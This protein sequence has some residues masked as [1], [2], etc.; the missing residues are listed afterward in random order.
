MSPHL[1][2]PAGSQQRK[3]L[4]DADHPSLGA[5]RRGAE[6]R[7]FVVGVGGGLLRHGLQQS[8]R[9]GGGDLL[10]LACW[11]RARARV[12]L[13]LRVAAQGHGV[14]PAQGNTRALAHLTLRGSMPPRALRPPRGEEGRRGLHG[15]LGA[16]TLAWRHAPMRPRGMSSNDASAFA[17]V[18]ET[19]RRASRPAQSAVHGCDLAPPTHCRGHGRAARRPSDALARRVRRRLSGGERRPAVCLRR[20]V[21]LA[22]HA[23]GVHAAANRRPWHRKGATRALGSRSATQ[24]VVR[25]CAGTC[26]SAIPRRGSGA[27]AAATLGA[28]RRSRLTPRAASQDCGTA[29]VDVMAGFM[30]D[31]FGAPTTLVFIAV[32]PPTS[33]GRGFPSAHAAACALRP[34][35][36]QRASL[37]PLG[38]Q[39]AQARSRV[40]P[41]LR[42]QVLNASGFLAIL[43]AYKGVVQTNYAGMV[44]LP[45]RCG[46]R[47]RRQRSPAWLT[48]VPRAAGDIHSHRLWGQ[49]RDAA[50]RPRHD[51]GQLPGDP[52]HGHRPDEVGVLPL[53]L[54]VYGG[55]QQQAAPAATRL[56][57]PARS[58]DARPRCVSRL[59]VVP[60]AGRE[61]GAIPHPVGAAACSRC[62]C[63]HP[64]PEAPAQAPLLRQLHGCR[65]CRCWRR[66]PRHAARLFRRERADNLYCALHGHHRAAAE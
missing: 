32:R 28:R 47:R 22:A 14:S 40:S 43:A 12:R 53:R 19:P 42:A 48:L 58:A 21:R 44:R 54:A 56:R 55:E 60:A 8:V 25:V 63:V 2:Q 51:A 61:G 64:F 30:F 7:V 24:P 39:R 52:R 31:A 29:V 66:G 46:R 17:P 35:R 65:R 41:A 4:A 27:L 5:R 37:R 50:A 10:L 57:L 1:E 36:L 62:A 34:L 23:A 15:K 3:K 18:N 38:L 9:P 49:W 33:A 13:Q 11:R 26:S 6:R 45:L 16:R 20:R 59:T